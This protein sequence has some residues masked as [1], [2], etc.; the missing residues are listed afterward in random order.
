MKDYLVS[1][2]RKL[3]FCL[4]MFLTKTTIGQEREI[5]FIIDTVITNSEEL[6]YGIGWEWLDQNRD[7][8]AEF[9][10]TDAILK[11]TYPNFIQEI[12]FY[13][14]VETDIIMPLDDKHGEFFIRGINRVLDTL[15]IRKWTVIQNDLS[16]TISTETTYIKKRNDSSSPPPY[17]VKTEFKTKKGKV[18]YSKVIRLNINGQDHRLLIEPSRMPL[19]TSGHGYRP[20]KRYDRYRRN[21]AK[22]SKKIYRYTYFHFVECPIMYRYRGEFHF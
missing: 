16:D 4:L 18:P 2:P 17:L 13:D 22:S 3:L 7:I 12:K 9:V 20:S 11:K 21:E 6:R 5:V 8:P 1:V 19:R 15:R 10:Y 14:S